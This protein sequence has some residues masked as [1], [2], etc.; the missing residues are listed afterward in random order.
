MK[1]RGVPNGIVKIIEDCGNHCLRLLQG[2]ENYEHESNETT[3]STTIDV[4][5][6]TNP[7]IGIYDL[8]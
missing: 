5:D 7:Y 4:S 1:V 8:K 6:T 3:P 2:Q